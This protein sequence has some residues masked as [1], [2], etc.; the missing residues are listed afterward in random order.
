LA[1]DLYIHCWLKVKIKEDWFIDLLSSRVCILI[2]SN[3]FPFPRDSMFSVQRFIVKLYGFVAL[4]LHA[5]V[6]MYDHGTRVIYPT[7]CLVTSIIDYNVYTESLCSLINEK[8]LYLTQTCLRNFDII[9]LCRVL[10]CRMYSAHIYLYKSLKVLISHVL[11][12]H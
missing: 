8:I 2:L 4:A 3:L 9:R 5:Y 6:Q 11:N 12:L 1:F 10:Y 7:L